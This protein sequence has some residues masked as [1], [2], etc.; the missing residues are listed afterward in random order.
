MIEFLQTYKFLVIPF[1]SLC[2]TQFLKFIFEGI[3]KK[4][5]DIMR[6]FNGNGGMPSTH[7]AVTSSLT[8]A[9]GLE[10]GF[11]S[12]AF[13]ITLVFT[14]IVLVDAMGVRLESEKQAEVINKISQEIKDENPT[15]SLK[16]LKDQI[17]HEPF[18][19]LV[20]IFFGVL[21]SVTFTMML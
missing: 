14:F 16:K 18:E 20:G 11:S 3:Q 9:I 4:K 5:F 8:V 15:F 7:S 19:V 12:I 13:A 10:Y 6:L 17:G 2:F 21:V 1:V